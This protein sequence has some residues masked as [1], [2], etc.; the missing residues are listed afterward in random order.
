MRFPV[1][2]VIV[3]AAYALPLSALTL[4]LD[5]AGAAQIVSAEGFGP[6]VQLG[7][8]GALRFGFPVLDWIQLEARL[9]I[10]GL[11]PSDASGGFTYRGLCGGSLGFGVDA[12]A[13]I[14]SW[15]RFGS[16]RAGGGLGAAAAIARYQYTTL[17][18]FYPEILAMGF[19]EYF[20]A[21][22]P[23]LDMRL[24]V[25]VK[26]ALRRDLAYAI[27]SGIGLGVSYHLGAAR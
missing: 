27:T 14:G 21:F 15:E 18:F 19:L 9:E 23:S 11:A 13:A 1:V 16:L 10:L 17:Y 7:G 25:P 8:G 24:F 3:L 4:G 22:L 6:K 5:G 20:P 26:A 12:S 2:L